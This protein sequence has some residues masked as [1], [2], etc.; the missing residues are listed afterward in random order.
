MSDFTATVLM[1][2]V[3]LIAQATIWGTYV[4]RRLLERGSRS[5]PSSKN[6]AVFNIG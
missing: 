4:R 5:T 1:V 3:T 2:I 6:V